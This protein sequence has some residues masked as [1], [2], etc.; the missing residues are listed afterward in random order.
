MAE[1]SGLKCCA[2]G[3]LFKMATIHY[4]QTF[5]DDRLGIRIPLSVG[6]NAK[7]ATPFTWITAVSCFIGNR[8]SG[9]LQQEQDF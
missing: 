8:T 5:L 6:F 1:G 3:F 4:E 2:D 9:F 7:E